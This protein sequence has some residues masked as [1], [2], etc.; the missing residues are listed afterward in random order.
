M[1]ITRKTQKEIVML[2][3]ASKRTANLIRLGRYKEAED[4]LRKFAGIVKSRGE[5]KVK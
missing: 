1:S 4:V 3:V 5:E 2:S